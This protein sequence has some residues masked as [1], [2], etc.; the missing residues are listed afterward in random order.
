MKPISTTLFD[1]YY[2][3]LTTVNKN[4]LNSL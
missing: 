4:I 3:I 1:F 2:V